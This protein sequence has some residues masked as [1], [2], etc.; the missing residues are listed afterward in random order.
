MARSHEWN[1]HWW[2]ADIMQHFSNP[3]IAFTKNKMWNDNIPP[4]SCC[5]QITV[6]IWLNLPMSSPKADLHNINAHIKFGEN[7]LRFNYSNYRPESK[8]WIYCG[9]ITLSKMDEICPLGITKQ[10][11]TI[12][13]HIL[14]L[15][16]I[17]WYLLKMK[18]RMCRGQITLSRIDEIC[19]SAIINQVSTI[20]MHTPS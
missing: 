19:P 14:S 18:K 2:Y 8:I 5:E 16:K 12:S 6:K 20:S 4:L 3:V 9:Q 7:P 11:S 17:H 10:I 1:S 15:V 13:T